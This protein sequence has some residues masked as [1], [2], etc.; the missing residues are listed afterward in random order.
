MKSV[1]SL[2]NALARM[3][4]AQLDKALY[5]QREIQK[6]LA[7]VSLLD[8][9]LF[10]KPD[11]RVNWHHR[12]MCDVLGKWIRKEITR[13]MVFTAPRH[14]KSELVSRRLPAFLFGLNPNERIIATSH[15]ADL[16]TSMNRDVQRIIDSPEYHAVFQNTTLFRDNVRATAKKAWLR[17]ND[18]FEIVG[19]RGVYR[20]AGV[21]GSITGHGGTRLIIDD[22]VKDAEQANSIT[23]RN[24]LWEWYGKVLRTRLEKNGTILLTVTRWH[25]D[26]LAGRL[27][28][29]AK[30]DPKAEQWHVLVIPAVCEELQPWD[31]RQIGDAL[32]PEEFP[33]SYFEEL[34]AID[35]MGFNALYQQR[36]SAQEGNIF[37][38]D[39]WRFYERLPEG[40]EEWICSWD[41]AVKDKEVNDYYVGQVWAKKG[42]NLFL[43]DQYRRKIEFTEGITVFLKQIVDYPKIGAK[44]IEDKANGSPSI[45][46]LK[47]KIS[48]IHP[49]NPHGSKQERAR[50]QAYWVKNGNVYL[51]QPTS[52][53]WVYEFIDEWANFPNGKHD[54]Q[55]D[56]GT[57]AFAYFAEKAPKTNLDIYDRALK[58]ELW[59]Y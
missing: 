24:R 27:L 25:E 34:K 33:L 19:H 59:G 31:P 26:D 38:R 55:V 28:S 8:F 37:K 39:Y 15:T 57:Q 51:P 16:A 1:H 48:G 43:V 53:N 11:Y 22:P 9:T 40:I 44:L 18:I 41:M 4:D 2:S 21:G 13:L 30:S 6:D 29:L 54:D 47:Q 20:C 49:I 14:G 23:Y 45:Q 52:A 7:R 36:P 50:A 56:A 17:N 46:V 10:T 35:S 5:I 42:A 32:W 3:N 12:V 58:G